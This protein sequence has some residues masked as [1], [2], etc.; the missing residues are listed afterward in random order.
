MTRIRIKKN[1]IFVLLTEII[2]LIHI[3][4]EIK[5]TVSDDWERF[6]DFVDFE[7]LGSECYLKSAKADNGRVETETFSDCLQNHSSRTV[8]QKNVFFK[9]LLCNVAVMDL[10]SK[11]LACFSGF[12]TTSLEHFWMAASICIKVLLVNICPT[13]SL[14]ISKN[15]KSY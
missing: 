11:L 14:D 1:T 15:P 5:S 2:I 10:C 4:V 6:S 9:K 8:S 13:K 12:E 3:P 7:S